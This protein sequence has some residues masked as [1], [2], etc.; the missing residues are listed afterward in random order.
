[1]SRISNRR[2]KIDVDMDFQQ[3]IDNVMKSAE[4]KNNERYSRRKLTKDLVNFFVN[5]GWEIEYNGSEFKLEYIKN[6]RK[7]NDKK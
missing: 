3:W 6:I 2:R 5:N 7:K 1:M 4:E